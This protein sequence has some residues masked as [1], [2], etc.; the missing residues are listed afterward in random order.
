[1]S[2]ARRHLE[3]M[4][5]YNSRRSVGQR[6]RAA[7]RVARDNRVAT[8]A[9][10]AAEPG[11]PLESHGSQGEEERRHWRDVTVPRDWVQARG[12]PLVA[13]PRVRT[14]RPVALGSL[15]LVLPFFLQFACGDTQAA[16]KGEG[17]DGGGASGEGDGGAPRTCGSS[18]RPTYD[19]ID[20]CLTGHVLSARVCQDGAWVCPIGTFDRTE[21]GGTRD[22]PFSEGGACTDGATGVIY[23][24]QCQDGKWSCPGGTRPLTSPNVDASVSDTDA[25]PDGAGPAPPTDGG[26]CGDA[27]LGCP[28]DGG[29]DEAS[30]LQ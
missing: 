16:R 30:A 6:G 20:G 1:M 19:C 8:P 5:S 11:R 13:W 3:S 2:G 21:C 14:R 17:N 26:L 25:A 12:T 28:A 27:G 18:P 29:R 23:Y 4:N 9:P 22:C 10:A 24:K 15:S 7:S